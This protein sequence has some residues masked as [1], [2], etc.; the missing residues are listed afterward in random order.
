MRTP[1]P[2][3]T[4]QKAFGHINVSRRARQTVATAIVLTLLNMPT[5]VGYATPRQNS[6]IGTITA[7][8]VVR[9]NGSPVLS[10]QTLFFDSAIVTSADSEST[11]NLA[12]SARLK[13]DQESSLTL[14][15][16]SHNFSASLG[17]GMVRALVPGSVR[18]DIR[19]ADAVITTDSAGAADFNVVVDVCS[20]TLVVQVG[21]VKIRAGDSVR[22]VSSGESFSTAPR[23]TVPPM[24]SPH[25]SRRKKVGLFL[26][27]AGGVTIL[28]IALTGKDKVVEMPSGGCVTVPSGP[29]VGGC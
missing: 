19:T 28:L 9:I 18:G 29:T 8:G 4:V 17:S 26:G 7:E 25:F 6:T 14:E 27:I 2:S 20:T 16:A 10:G 1:F 15:S 22:L 23:P 13:L 12:N 11:L 5:S 21:R 3:E 24:P